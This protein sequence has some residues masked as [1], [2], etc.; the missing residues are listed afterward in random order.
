MEEAME[1]YPAIDIKKGQCVRLYQG[2]FDQVT[3][4]HDNPLDVALSWQKQGAQWI[5]IVDLDG[6]LEGQ[7]T[8]G[9][10]IRD[11]ALKT[12]AKTQTGGGIRSLED[13]ALRLKAG[14]DRVIIGTQAV[15]DPLFVKKAVAHF[16]SEAIVVGIDAKQ[17]FVATHGWKET[18]DLKA[19][20]FALEMGQY[21]VKTIVF[22]DVAKDGTMEGPNLEE[23]KKMI[24]ATGLNIIA[25]GGVSQLTDVNKVQAIGAAGVI[26]GKALYS[27]AFTLKD[28]LAIGN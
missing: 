26:I 20:D 9:S 15:K 24:Q 13:I 17:G 25:S 16:G 27:K 4:Y 1:L 28:A 11:I 22:T 2:E 8:N 3:T 7:W 14:I 10:I 21:G 18:S 19:V 23:T 5:H 12:S 6:A